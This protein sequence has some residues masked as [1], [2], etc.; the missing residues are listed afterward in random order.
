MKNGIRQPRS[1]PFISGYHTESFCFVETQSRRI[2]FVYID[3]CRPSS[4]GKIH[5]DGTITVSPKVAI[6]KKHFY[7][8]SVQSDETGISFLVH[9]RVK[10]Y[11]GEIKRNQSGFYPLEV[12]LSQK[13]VRS[14]HRPLPYPSKRRIIPFIAS[15]YFHFEKKLTILAMHALGTVEL[16]ISYPITQKS[17]LFGCFFFAERQVPF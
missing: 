12:F 8:L 13:T 3:L 6:D 10:L 7:H 9:N 1:I 16:R 5:Q 11:R 2:L 14:A 4:H 15:H 17:S